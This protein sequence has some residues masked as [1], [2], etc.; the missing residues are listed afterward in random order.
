MAGDLFGGTIH[1][2]VFVSLA[3][4]A[5]IVSSTSSSSVLIMIK[6]LNIW[7]LH[8]SLIFAMTSFELMYDVFF[9]SCMVDTGSFGLTVLSN[10]A[11]CL[12]GTTSS[13]L[14]NVIALVAL[15]V[16]YYRKTINLMPYY[17]LIIA[18]ASIPGMIVIIM[19]MMVLSDVKYS[20]LVDVGLTGIYYYT[21]LASIG[22]NFVCSICTA[23]TVHRMKSLTN[24]RSNAEIAINRLSMRMFYYPIVQAIGRSGCAWY[25]MEY[26]YNYQLN[27]TVNL[28]P[29][30]TS[31][32]EFGVQCW[33]TV[34]IPLIAVGYL[35]IFLIMQPDASKSVTSLMKR[36][37]L[38]QGPVRGD[39]SA[40]S[41]G[42]TNNTTVLEF[43]TNRLSE[44]SM[45]S[46]STQ[47]HA[48]ARNDYDEEE[49]GQYYTHN[50]E[51]GTQ[52]EYSSRHSETFLH[53]SLPPSRLNSAESETAAKVINAKLFDCKF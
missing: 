52:S 9:F 41:S 12:G 1:N 27:R 13:M 19:Y 10:I 39:S 17:Y 53:D 47:Q 22:I 28:D 8:L 4:I 29:P 38:F 34:C 7:N 25:E 14:S 31:D 35:V 5:T 15:Y 6:R 44:V 32:T 33:M 45:K 43:T 24:A 18:V 50:S 40:S 51:H 37:D 2:Q 48:A 46:S 23:V 49:E 21:R 16:V 20:Y 42:G 11:V 3:L 26:G 36:W 30:D